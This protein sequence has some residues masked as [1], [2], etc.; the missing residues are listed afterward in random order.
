MGLNWRDE[1]K[2]ISFHA[3]VLYLVSFFSNYVNQ[4]CH[5]SPLKFC[6]RFIHI[7]LASAVAPEEGYYGSVSLAIS[8]ITK[9][10]QNIVKYE[11]I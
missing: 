2:S 6:N 5:I 8:F 9:C 10:H 11:V 3:S 7:Y 1:I 4:S